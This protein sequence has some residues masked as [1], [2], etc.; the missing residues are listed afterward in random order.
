VFI[1]EGRVYGDGLHKLEPKE[2]DNAIKEKILE[3]LP[4]MSVSEL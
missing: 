4:K 1:G 2:L 3:V